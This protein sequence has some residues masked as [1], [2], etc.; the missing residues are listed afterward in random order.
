VT[1][2]DKSSNELGGRKA[3]LRHESGLSS[4]PDA[5]LVGVGADDPSGAEQAIR[6]AAHEA[7]LGGRPLH[8][9]SVFDRKVSAARATPDDDIVGALRQEAHRTMDA[10][11]ATVRREFADLTVAGHVVQGPTI[12][13]LGTL[14][15]HAAM[16]VVGSRHRGALARTILGSVGAALAAHAPCPVVVMCGSGDAYDP[17]RELVVGVDADGT[18]E[19]VLDFALGYASRTG[20]PV[21]A[22]LVVPPHVFDTDEYRQ[23][24][25]I[26]L[27]WLEQTVSPYREK[28]PD[29]DLRTFVTVDHVVAALATE[30][31]AEH[32]LVVGRRADREHPAFHPASVSH[33]ALHYAAC[34][35]AVVPSHPGSEG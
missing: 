19:T 23:P 1:A 32:M 27:E 22:M 35:V 9:V 3:A 34:P 24:P 13:T 2:T 10:A 12:E 16:L 20:H 29:V 8:I 6:W 30:S 5:I 33:R 7:Q 14:G 25:P 11:V 17:P 4:D 18:A 21:R 26:A 28:H 31:L 15:A